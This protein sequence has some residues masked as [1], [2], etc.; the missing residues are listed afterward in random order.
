MQALVDLCLAARC[1]VVNVLR[2]RLV[3]CTSKWPYACKLSPQHKRASESCRLYNRTTVRLHKMMSSNVGLCTVLVPSYSARALDCCVCT[4]SIPHAFAQSW[5]ICVHCCQ[6]HVL[7]H[8]L[9]PILLLC[10][11]SVACRNVRV[12]M[13]IMS[14]LSI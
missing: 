14:F 3:V 10:G 5:H 12:R 11:G 8:S 13:A 9:S 6:R 1:I 7:S 2:L 4:R